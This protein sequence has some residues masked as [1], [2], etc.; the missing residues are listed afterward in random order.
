MAPSGPPNNLDMNLL[1]KW[2]PQFPESLEALQACLM[3]N[4][5]DRAYE[6]A[7]LIGLEYFQWLSPNY[8]S[9]HPETVRKTGTIEV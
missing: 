8:W 1:A 3:S 6:F 2:T 5:Q 7:Q 4:E 9:H